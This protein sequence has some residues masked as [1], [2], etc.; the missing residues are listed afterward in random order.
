[1]SGP[2]KRVTLRDV[3]AAASL[4]PAAASYALRGMQTSRETQ[5]RVRRVADE[6]GYF[7]NPIARALV[8]GR[9]D[10]VGVLCSSLGDLWQ[11]LLAAGIGRALLG[12][13]RYALIV[14]AAGEPPRELA[15]ARQLRDQRVDALIVSPLDPSAALWA[16]VSLELPVISI[17][18]S[19]Q[20]VRAGGAVLFD[21]RQGVRSALDHLAGL[22]HRRV[23]VLTPTRAST[24][25]RPAEQQV[26][27]EAAR[28][29]LD[30]SIVSSPPSLAE[31]ELA[32]K[33][34][35]AAAHPPTAVFCFSDTIAYGVYGAARDLG[36]QI[37]RDLSVAGYDNHPVSRLLS[38][39]LTT[40]D[41]DI[42]GIIRDAAFLV[43][44]AIDGKGRS[45]RRI[46]KAP[47]LVPGQS[48][49]QCSF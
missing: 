10:T 40:F 27:V 26:S 23:T 18:D 22:G 12:A 29:R 42:D 39:A 48:T 33:E 21:N 13:D 32:A 3:A 36:L 8:S 14:D 6:L 11:Q 16:E 25:D 41:W 15:L 4:S 28:L 46:I 34:V 37:P 31:A 5:E 47:V 49:A 19:L 43:G 30:V 38:P 9:T 44:A 7:V 1:V 17:G 2:K 20:G 35:L 45:R 24:P